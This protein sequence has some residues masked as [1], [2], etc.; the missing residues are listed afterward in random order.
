M[1]KDTKQALLGF[2]L[3]FVL[4]WLLT[5]AIDK[6]KGDDTPVQPKYTDEDIAVSVTAYRDAMAAGESQEALDELNDEL[7][8]E[9]G[10]TVLFRVSD[11]KFVVK[12]LSGREV[13]VV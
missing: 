8:K 9:Y 7:K 4:F 12:N 13:K 10:L 11:Q 1:N 2:G 6:S 5:K 3:G